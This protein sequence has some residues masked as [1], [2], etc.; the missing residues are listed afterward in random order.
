M[1]KV[2]RERHFPKLHNAHLR[3]LRSYGIGVE[4]HSSDVITPEMEQKLL[5]LGI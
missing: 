1:N 2:E 3:M 5:S 4:R